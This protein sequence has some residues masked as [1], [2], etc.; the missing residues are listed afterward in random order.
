M[1][2]QEAATRY[3]LIGTKEGVVRAWA[4]KRNTEKEQWSAEDILNMAGA[5]ARPNPQAPGN[6]IPIHIRIEAGGEPAMEETRPPRVETEPRRTY[7]KKR[8]F[9]KHGYTEGCE[10]C[11]RLRTGCMT[12]RPHDEA[13]RN[14]IGEALR[15]EDDP[16]YRRYKEAADQTVWEEM[17]RQE[18]EQ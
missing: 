10:G 15:K 1:D 5:P 9:E 12:A 3:V 11:R 16:R 17:Q 7:L 6:D 4:T 13:C 8:D 2:T 18:K 14:R